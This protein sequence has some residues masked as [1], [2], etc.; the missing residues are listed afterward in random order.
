MKW[1]AI[2]FF[3][4]IAVP[5][6]ILASGIV[7]R[8]TR[9]FAARPLLTRLSLLPILLISGHFLLRPHQDTFLGLD[10]SCY[11]LM[12]AAFQHGRGFDEIDKTLEEVP[13][14]LRRTFLLEYEHWGRDTRDRS[15]ELPD[16][17]TLK[18]RPFFYPTLPLASWGFSILTGL[19]PDLFLPLVGYLW[20]ALLLFTSVTLGGVWGL[21]AGF[22][23]LA[24]TPLPAWFLRGYYA[25]AAAAALAA[26]VFLAWALSIN[27]RIMIIAGSFLLGAAI[28][29]HPVAV[30]FAAPGIILLGFSASNPRRDVPVSLLVLALALLPLFWMTSSICQPYGNL[31]NWNSLRANLRVSAAHQLMAVAA[32]LAAGCCSLLLAFWPRWQARLSQWRE[33][34]H[35]PGGIVGAIVIA[36]IPLIVALTLWSQKHLAL[37]GLVEYGSGLRWT[38]GTLLAAAIWLTLRERQYGRFK[39][40][41]LIVMAL[42]PIFFYL[43]GFERLPLLWSH[44]RLVP[45]TILLITAVGPAL[46]IGAAAWSARKWRRWPVGACAVAALLLVGGFANPLRWPA[47][48]KCRFEGKTERFVNEVKNRIGQRLAIFDYY[49]NAVPF[50]TDNRS[51]VLGLGDYARDQWPAVAAW[52]ASRAA[53]EEVWC[54]T[55]YSNPGIEE[56]VRLESMGVEER[57]FSRVGAPTALP[58]IWEPLLIHMDFLAV[59]PVAPGTVP[60]VLHKVFDGGPLA[61]RGRWKRCDIPMKEGEP[62]LAACRGYHGSGVIGPVPGPGGAASITVE[63]A[64]DGAHSD[65]QKTLKLWSPWGESSLLTIGPGLTRATVLIP[66]PRDVS[67]NMASTGLYRMTTDAAVDPLKVKDRDLGILI[68]SVTI[69]AVKS[70]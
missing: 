62:W 33:R 61:Q 57:L 25:E 21:A 67:T 27:R 13:P 28:S 15:F 12:T 19:H 40:L 4:G 23:L 63:A 45:L 66:V 49:P 24:G 30:S 36:C 48:Y 22:A 5:L 10:T 44:R 6:V 20:V 34:L 31:L 14:S 68:H 2:S 1:L 26:T 56:G 55:A 52:M 41:F 16:L 37:K 59:H 47:P 46:A 50:T 60:P 43:R 32:V 29:L 69:E 39:A 7:A 11:R 70:P 8:L 35:S 64:L 53:T 9:S 17:N 38:Y 54:V 42:A 51:R 58:A 3:L 18:S 65:V